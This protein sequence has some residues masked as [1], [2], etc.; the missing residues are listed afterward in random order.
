MLAYF[1]TRGQEPTEFF[2]TY[3][4]EFKPKKRRTG[5]AKAAAP[6]RTSN[7]NEGKATSVTVEDVDEDES[8]DDAGAP[9]EKGRKTVTK[10]L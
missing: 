9:P 7:R 5:H 1:G 8:M 2:A 6:T 3:S 10:G 4:E